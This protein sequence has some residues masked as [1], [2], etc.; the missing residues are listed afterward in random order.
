MEIYKNKISLETLT[1]VRVLVKMI[2][3]EM[4][5]ATRDPIPDG[6]LLH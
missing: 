1:M 5:M 3:I 4:V 6:Y 2:E